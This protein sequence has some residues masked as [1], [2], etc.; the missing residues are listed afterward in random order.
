MK[1][2]IL[3]SFLALVM[4]LMALPMMGQDW[5]EIHFKD[6]KYR[7]FYLK[8]LIDFSPSKFDS[9]GVQHSNYD[10]QRVVTKDDVFIYKLADVDSISFTKYEEEI[11]KKN[12]V[13]AM[14]VVFNVLSNN[15]TLADVIKHI[16]EIKKS[17][18]VDN[19][20]SD[21]H[22][23]F[24]KVKGFDVVP[25]HFSHDSILNE[26]LNLRIKKE[27]NSKKSPHS[28]F[29]YISSTGKP[30]R[31]VIANQTHFDY[32]F[33]NNVENYY[34][35]LQSYFD[36]CNIMVDYIKRPTVDFFFENSSDPNNTGS[37]NLYDYDIIILDT[38]GGYDNN[39]GVHDFLTAEILGAVN[40]EQYTS[41]SES[42][43][44]GSFNMLDL[45]RQ[46]Y[47]G[48]T[49][50]DILLSYSEERDVNSNTRWILHPSLTEN[51]FKYRAKG[52]FLN[53]NSIFFNCACQSLKGNEMHSTYGSDNQVQS[54]YSLAN[55]FLNK[56]LGVY[57][58]YNES[59]YIS[60]YASTCSFIYMMEG[61][62]LDKACYALNEIARVQPFVAEKEDN[63]DGYGGYS[64]IDYS[65]L[66]RVPDLSNNQFGKGF[67]VPVQTEELSNE[68]ANQEYNQSNTVIVNG[69]ATLL[70]LDEDVIK[71]GFAVTY[72]DPIG[73]TQYVEAEIDPICYENNVYKFSA[74]LE[75]LERN[76]TYSYCAYTYDG[77]NYN[78]GNTCSFKIDKIN[79]LELST[80]SI[81][82]NVGQ[83]TVVDIT[84][85]SGSYVIESSDEH[86]A[87]AF[88]DGNTISINALNPGEDTI[89]VSD[90]ITGQTAMIAVTVTGQADTR[91][92]M[93][94]KTVNK[95][96]YSIYKK[97]LDENDYRTNPDGWKCY[98]S[99]LVLDI[100]KEGKTESYVVDDNIYLDKQNNHHGGQQPCMVL[101]FKKGMIGIFCNSKETGY[102][103]DMDGYYYS[104]S[105]NNVS[106]SKE[107][108]FEGYN[109]GW[110]P[111]F[112][113]Y[114]DDNVNLCNF[115][116]DGYFTILAIRKSGEWELYYDNKDITPE[117]AQQI[118]ERIGSVLVIDNNQ[119]DD[120]DNRIPDIIPEDFR[121]VI[122]DY[123]PIYDGMNPPNIEGAYFLSPEILI[124][125]SLSGDQIGRKYN[126]YYQKY[127]NQDMVNN[128]IDMVYVSE[129]ESDWAKGSGA[130]ISGTGNNFTVFFNLEGV[131]SGIEYKSAEVVS[132]TKTATGIKNLTHGFIMTEKGDDPEHK[133]VDVGTFRFFT[134]QDGM[135]EATSW[136]FGNQYGARKRVKQDIDLP[137][138][139]DRCKE[140]LT[141]LK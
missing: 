127:G 119:N 85:G 105:M 50:D 97:T 79:N 104:T 12:Y 22:Q 102:N 29:E 138:A 72:Y 108:V 48:V 118:W 103:Y 122:E 36:D 123:I 136:P 110:F 121:D 60:P 35:L 34:N 137:D 101:D 47:D 64:Y 2:T 116:Y 112:R 68:K 17:E 57:L 139:H 99:E 69:K 130:F 95:T 126:S 58:G 65:Y 113:D 75:N 66:M 16:D 6:G 43:L 88:I 40:M 141:P 86:V 21:G 83:S 54:N 92:L 82:L 76:R 51:F 8:Y 28:S 11:A 63:E 13:D 33:S 39:T 53:P 124:G 24:V 14:T 125:S 96:V 25:F 15:P 81:S 87:T 71:A 109:W 26:D 42:D 4:V 90:K 98:R 62:S 132:G 56:G 84:S 74:T 1:N 78:Y 93:V 80:S 61:Y 52:L 10:Y 73:Y 18:G 5:M 89:I 129:Y 133:L 70:S 140:P 31:A 27:K 135:S 67:I 77:M 49:E 128:T 120:V 131:S 115:S 94:T 111:Y 114:G 44:T 107:A 100:I 32:E 46:K 106:F 30:L 20:W 91:E 9:N 19:A 134:D 37:L 117:V 55:T 38:H 23:L 3:K 59:N 41:P 7:K 45:L